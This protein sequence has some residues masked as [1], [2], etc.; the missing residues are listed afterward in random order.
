MFQQSHRLRLHQLR[1]HVAEH[2]SDSVES[3]IGVAD[4]GETG[5]VEEDLLDDEDGDCLGE[6]RA[7]LHDAQAEGNDLGGK[8]E[9]DDLGVVVLLGEGESVFNTK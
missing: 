1:H 2:R 3:L 4:V 7:S 6:L 8:E 9:V 5:L